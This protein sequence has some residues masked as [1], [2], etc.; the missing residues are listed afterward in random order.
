MTD[1]W[2]RRLW[3]E[4]G[5]V[6]DYRSLSR[7][8]YAP[9]DPATWVGIWRCLYFDWDVGSAR[10]RR[11]RGGTALCPGVNDIVR[12]VGVAV[13]SFPTIES[14]ARRHALRLRGEPGARI[15]F[16][17]RNLRTI[18]RVI[19]HPQFRGLGIASRLVRHVCR[20]C[21]TRYVEAFA[22]MG[23]VHPLFERGGMKR[24]EPNYFFLDRAKAAKKSGV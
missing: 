24:L 16:L 3:I 4:P 1:L 9:G 7:F 21:M 12:V 5:T 20:E 11:T 8:H 17:N 2:K 15:A 13:L 19:V 14:S 18:S 23:A 10:V 22:R 6:R